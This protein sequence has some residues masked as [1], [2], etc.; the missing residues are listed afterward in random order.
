[1]QEFSASTS[2]PSS[3]D[4]ADEELLVHAEE[5]MAQ[6]ANGPGFDPL[7]E[8][9]GH[10][11]G[12]GGKRLRARL[13][14]TAAE[15]LGGDKSKV[16][17]WAAACELLHNA[18]LVHDDLQDG[19]IQR[20]GKPAVWVK[21][22]A[23]QAINA[24]D[25]ML[26]LPYQAIGQIDADPSVKW[27]LTDILTDYALTTVRGQALEFTLLEK[28]KNGSLRASFK[29]A[30]E[31]KT[32]ALFQAPVHG[33]AILSGYS[34]ERSQ[35]IANPFRFLGLLFQFQDDVLDL[36]GNKGREM[37]GT[38]LKEGKISALVVEHLALHPED[39]DWLLGALAQS[40]EETADADVERAIASFRDGGALANVLS[41]I[42]SME[43]S[44]AK[45]PVLAEYA[46]LRALVDSFVALILNPIRHVLDENP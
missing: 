4:T 40:R 2:R 43:Q 46:G 41:Q 1:M 9:V 11:L 38:D 30:V 14:L 27:F 8:I 24:G 36:Y 23:P 25:L 18:T 31:G 26:M 21:Y 33:S 13:A 37:A 15:V 3:A 45:S 42:R 39:S 10:H 34:L 16:V 5:L 17:P 29:Q 20:R 44:L 22:G 32:S 28:A 35:E 7:G 19:D 12:T 6:I